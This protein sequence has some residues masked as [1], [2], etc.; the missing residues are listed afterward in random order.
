MLVFPSS[1]MYTILI[2]K[3]TPRDSVVL[4]VVVDSKCI[5]A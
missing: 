1:I 3:A 2:D 4:S 5:T